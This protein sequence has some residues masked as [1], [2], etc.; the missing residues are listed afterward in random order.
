PPSGISKDARKRLMEYY[1]PGNVRELRNIL[2]R[3]AILC[4][5]GLITPEHLAIVTAPAVGSVVERP[6]AA[7]HAVGQAVPAMPAAPSGDLAAVER[8]MIE[9]ALHTARFNKS[10]AAA[11]LGLTRAQLYVRM[12]KH[13]LE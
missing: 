9:Q 6:P 13:G 2:E 1:W 8:A 3:A 11:A 12:R 10:K 5:G 4:D 7:A